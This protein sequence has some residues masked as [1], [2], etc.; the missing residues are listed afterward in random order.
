MTGYWEI[1][2]KID[3]N[4]YVIFGKDLIRFRMKG[5]IMKISHKM[6]IIDKLKEIL[7]V[8]KWKQKDLA[9][10]L[11]VS[12]KTMS[13]WLNGKKLPGL[14]NTNKIE[15]LYS[16]LYDNNFL[17]D[18]VDYAIQDFQ[19]KVELSEEEKTFSITERVYYDAKSYVMKMEGTNCR[20]IYLFPSIGKVPDAWYKVGGRSLLFYKMILAPRL[21]REARIR[22]DTDKVYR[23][24]HGIVSVKWGD[25]LISEAVGLGYKAER[26][27]FGIIVVDF[28]KE[29]TE[30]E[31][32]SMAESIKEERLRLKKMIKPKVNYPDI[33]I[34]VNDLVRVLPSKIK[35]LDKDYKTI[36]GNELLE[37][38]VEILKIYFRMA[39]GRMERRDAKLEMLE[40]V[41]DIMAMIYL[42]DECRML[43]VTARTMMGENVV[44]IRNAIE[45]SL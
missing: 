9:G 25:K 6:T 34:A 7:R 4:I 27:K 15:E 41:D 45:K 16:G 36:L 19:S 11:N 23:F 39:N 14:E 31:I 17:R 43:N 24:N 28:L 35:K 30:T 22:D 8:K 5:V 40:R 2:V 29:F 26:V 3:Q 21:G 13:F 33:I 20:Y 44:R 37:P 1:W 18:E 42:M 38:A 10:K 12:E 32:R